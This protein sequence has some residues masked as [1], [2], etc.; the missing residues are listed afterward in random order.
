[1]V[2]ILS[3]FVAFSENMIFKNED[4]IKVSQTATNHIEN[5][6]TFFL[7]VSTKT[8]MHNL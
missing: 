8:E 1:M 6:R 3:I 7:V 4:F 5:I 2:K